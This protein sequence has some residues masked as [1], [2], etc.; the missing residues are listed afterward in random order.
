M[1]GNARLGLLV[2]FAL[3]NRWIKR[4]RILQGP[5]AQACPQREGVNMLYSAT[6]SGCSA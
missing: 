1:R 6:V 3:S 4:K 5:K 2:M